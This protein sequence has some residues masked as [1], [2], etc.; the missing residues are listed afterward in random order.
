MTEKL[1][2]MSDTEPGSISARDSGLVAAGDVSLSG[3]IVAGRDVVLKMPAP[4]LAARFALPRDVADFTGRQAEIAWIE[5]AVKTRRII[6]IFDGPGIG[7]TALANHAAHRLRDKFPAAQLYVRL[8]GEQQP[9]VSPD[10]ALRRLLT[11]LGVGAESLPPDFEDQLALYRSLMTAGLLVLDNAMSVA[12]VEPLLP[13]SPNCVTLI[14]SRNPL[15]GLEGTHPLDLGRLTGAEARELLDKLLTADRTTAEPEAV[16][17]I[18]ELCDALPLALRIAASLLNTPSR[19]RLPLATFV[20]SLTGERGRLDLLRA[21]DRGVRASFDLSYAALSPA[22]ARTFRLLGLLNIPEMS[23][24][25]AVSVGGDPGELLDA[26]LME[27]GDRVWFH[28]LMRLFAAERAGEEETAGDREAAVGRAYHWA[29]EADLDFERERPVLL[30]LVRQAAGTDY[31]DDEVVWRLAARMAAFFDARGYRQDWLTVAETAVGAATRLADPVA[32]GTSLHHLSWVQ[33]LQRHTPEAL[34]TATEALRQ[35]RLAGDDRLRADILAHL[36]ALQRELHRYQDAITVLDEAA[37]DYRDLGDAH[38][39]GLVLRTLGH[40]LTRRRELP[41]AADTLDR[42]V[43]LLAET[44]DAVNEGWAHN[45][46]ISAR[47]SLWQEEAALEH[48]ARAR[49]IF[50]RTEHRLGAAWAHNHVGRVHRQYGRLDEAVAAHERAAELFRELDDAYGTGWALIDLGIARRDAAVIRQGLA[51]VDEIGER[52]ATAWALIALASLESDA[53]AAQ[54]ARALFE[55]TGSLHGQGAAL[56]VLGDLARAAG[57]SGD[58][59]AYYE[60]SLAPLRQAADPQREREALSR[61][62]EMS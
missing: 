9:R 10:D 41:D 19:R 20:V 60:R 6:V 12:Q 26:H 14:T 21:G 29:L 35:A 39:E 32:L 8:G 13:A 50:T 58:A 42:A 37:Q 54:D 15:T 5:E 40:V 52:D 34:E 25:L 59:R 44:G 23:R 53:G 48:F 11:Q 24:E 46:L 56:L 47:M 18:I 49:D 36:G 27:G 30:A 45:N 33:R 55:V 43:A 1:K 57:D 31:R 2:S 22:S 28:D 38:G 16:A 61:L 7:K 3:Q 17:R 4:S 51:I 62:E